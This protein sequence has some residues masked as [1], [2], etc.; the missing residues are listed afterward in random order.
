MP[1]Q[2]LTSQKRKPYKT[3]VTDEQWGLIKD[4]IPPAVAKRGRRPTDLRE[5]LNTILYQNKT[6]CPWDMLPH[7]LLPKSTVFDYYKAWQDQGIWQNILDF[8]RGKVRLATP[9]APNDTASAAAQEPSSASP[10]TGQSAAGGPA[11]GTPV[12]PP[13]GGAVGLTE[14]TPSAA[15]AKEVAVLA[16]PTQSGA[17]QAEVA[18]ECGGKFRQETP[19]FAIMDSQSCKTTEVGGEERGYD[20]GKKV[21]GRKRHIAVDSMGLLLAVVVTAANVSDG[22]GACLLLEQL[23]KEKFPR[24]AG[25]CGDMRYNDKKFIAA[26]ERR[27][28]TLE[29]KSRPPGSKGFV[30]LKK[31]W[32]VERTFAWLG[33]NRRLSK[34]YERT[35]ASSESRVRIAAIGMMLRRLTNK[36]A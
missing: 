29:V 34:D 13:E 8:V 10:A 28:L 26:L 9:L 3:D 23:S 18:A 6:E 20:G 17:A 32:I 5:V 12:K 11:A 36:A 24:L 16:P 7:D 21:K 33:F 19:S 22:R 14:A 1:E 31:R 30:L 35:V 15:V 25:V 27:G 2:D 4:L